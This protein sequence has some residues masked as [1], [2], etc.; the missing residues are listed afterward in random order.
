MKIRS[1]KN[2]NTILKRVLYPFIAI[3][4]LQAV[5]YIFIFWNG[6]SISNLESNAKDILNERVLNRKIYIETDMLH[7]WRNMSEVEEKI[8][9]HVQDVLDENNAELDDIKTNAELNEK[10]ME[11]V[12]EDIIYLL[13][14]NMVTGAFMVLD[15]NGAVADSY[16]G[17]AGF[18]VRDMDPSNYSE[19]GSDI[20]MEVGMPQLSKKLRI[21]LDSYWDSMFHFSEPGDNPKDNFFYKPLIAAKEQQSKYSSS[22]DF[23]YWCPYSPLHDESPEAITY[24]IPLIAD[25]GTVFGVIGVDITYQYIKTLLNYGEIIKDKKGAYIF[26]TKETDSNMYKV[27]LTDG[28]QY[29]IHFMN[30]NELYSTP[31]G[32]NEIEYFDTYDKS[33]KSKILGSVQ[34]FKLYNVNTPFEDEKWYLIGMTDEKSLL[35]VSGQTQTQLLVSAVIAFLLGILGVF[36]VSWIITKPIKVLMDDLKNSDPNKPISLHKINIYEIDKLADS[37]ELLS[38]KVAESAAKLSKIIK[39]SNI[40]IAVFEYLEDGKSVYCSQNIF[41]VLHIPND[42]FSRKERDIIPV[43]EFNMLL[44]KM[45]KYTH[46]K[47]DSVYKISNESGDYWVRL[48]LEKESERYLGL[49]FDITKDV[50]EKQKIEFERD[51]D[52]LT[53][54]YNRYAFSK[55]IHNLFESKKSTIKNAAMIM[56]DLDNLKYI[57]DTYGHDFGDIYIHEFGKCLNMLPKGNSLIARR[58]GDEFYTFI[59]GYDTKEDVDE[60]ISNFS[61]LINNKKIRLPNGDYFGLKVSAGVSWYPK[62]SQSY[63]ELIKYADFAMYSAKHN[64]KGSMM[65]FNI[66]DYHENSFLVN[67]HGDLNR[68]IDNQLVNFAM[69]PILS[70]KTGEIYGYEMLMRPQIEALKNPSTILKL[71]SSQSKLIQIERLTFFKAME[72]YEKRLNEGMVLPNAK[73]F[74]NSIRSVILGKEDREEFKRL[75]GKYFDNVVIEITE[76]EPIDSESLESKITMLKD[77]GVEV[78]I[79]DL[80]TGYNSESAILSISPEIVKIDISIIKDIDKDINR[81]ELL[82]SIMRFARLQN[83]LVLAEGV[84]TKE[85]L[86]YL[87]SE[88]IDYLQG[89]YLGKPSL[90]NF[91]I[92]EETVKE[93]IQMNK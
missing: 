55:L 41:D 33:H 23:G 27:I 25:D 7:N 91:D 70:A 38:S 80:G 54:M 15:G 77:F 11:R 49:L 43:S 57:N 2:K 6:G 83:V 79:D 9:N 72:V 65:E 13:R 51:Y 34:E 37:V 78:A 86:R 14:K 82:R 71:A 53:E 10:I 59:Y 36:Y 50:L 16:S 12:S 32:Y 5:L 17:N 56:W 85:E 40:P 73:I 67:A 22:K 69:Q 88:G 89:Y 45:S 18:Y 93:I 60:E 44:S 28:P 4:V 75:Y 52:S 90:D 92:S 46:D 48:I 74:I 21:S 68:L 35:E 84:E 76:S 66:D 81:Q 19:G 64:Y 42:G 1:V 63:E 61:R 26:A 24:S 29:K 20:L 47:Q 62:D 3:L 30:E 58:S 39:I 31:S 8:I 87:I